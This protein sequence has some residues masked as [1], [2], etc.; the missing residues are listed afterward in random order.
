MEE[1]WWVIPNNLAEVLNNELNRELS[2]KH[3]LYGKKAVAVAK[4]ED[5]DDVIY[6]IIELEK[7]AIVHLTYTNE[8]SSEYPKTQLFT[9]KEL[10]KHCKE[11]AEFY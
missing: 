1:P 2:T 10:E 6:W 8:T 7:Y 9:L 4:R 11:V 5:N 3:I